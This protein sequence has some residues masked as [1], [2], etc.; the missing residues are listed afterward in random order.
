MIIV[1]ISDLH[2][3]RKGGLVVGKVDTAGSLARCVEKILKLE[4]RADALFASGD[5]TENGAPEEYRHLHELLAPLTMPVYLMPGNHD[6]RDSLCAAFPG[7]KYLIPD[8]AQTINPL[9]PGE[10]RVREKASA[11]FLDYV[12]EMQGLRMIALD[13]VV[14]RRGGG[15]LRAEQLLWLDERLADAETPALI[16]LHHPPFATGIGFMDKIALA[17]PDELGRVIEKHHN[18]EAIVCG[19]VH[20]AM[21]RRWHGTVA[22]SCPSPA[23]QITLDLRSGGSESF[24]M[25]PPGFLLHYWNGTNLVS[26]TVPAGDFAGPYSFE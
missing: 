6:D 10:G 22:M 11:A 20:R 25:E 9:P 13:T 14:P 5:L 1:Q 2:V 23:H 21:C 18:V 3:T 24:I 16:F 7:H 19:H 26:H 4:P 8:A 15:M 12:V 17:N